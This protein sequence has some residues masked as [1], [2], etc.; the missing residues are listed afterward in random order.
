MHSVAAEGQ[1]DDK[2][3]VEK[4]Y[5][6]IFIFQMQELFYEHY[7]LR[8]GYIDPLEDPNNLKLYSSFT[9]HPNK[10][11]QYQMKLHKFMRSLRLQELSVKIKELSR[12]VLTMKDQLDMRPNM[13]EY[14]LGIPPSLNRFVPQNTNEVRPWEF[15]NDKLWYSYPPSQARRSISNDKHAATKHLVM[16][17]SYGLVRYDL[18]HH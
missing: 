15:M 18:L 3:L 1:F 10:N 5:T 16:R 8:K 12:D 17:V 6:V 9:L 4:V 13:E 14:M 2:Q 7:T 11:P